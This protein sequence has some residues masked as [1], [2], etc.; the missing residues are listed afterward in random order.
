MQKLQFYFEQRAQINEQLKVQITRIEIELEFERNQ[1]ESFQR[2]YQ[3]A[4]SELE[5]L[6][7]TFQNQSKNYLTSQ[8]KLGSLEVTL[9]D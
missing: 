2:K 6:K 9:A 3:E 5:S 7:F 8:L 4:Y 1:R